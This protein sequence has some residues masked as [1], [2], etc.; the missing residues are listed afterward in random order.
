VVRDGLT[1]I[2]LVIPGYLDLLLGDLCN[3]GEERIIEVSYGVMA[4]AQALTLISGITVVVGVSL[5]V[6]VSQLWHFQY[7]PPINGFMLFVKAVDCE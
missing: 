4:Y 6:R 1:V 3:G 7:H 5:W 2:E